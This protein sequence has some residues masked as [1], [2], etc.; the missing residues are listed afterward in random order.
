MKEVSDLLM[1]NIYKLNL[2]RKKDQLIKA[3]QVAKKGKKG[4]W[5][6]SRFES[7]MEYKKRTKV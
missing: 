1:G 7:P 2:C 3:E 4:M 5:A 6:Q